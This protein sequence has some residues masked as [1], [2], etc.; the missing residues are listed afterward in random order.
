MI[1]FSATLIEPI[2]PSRCRSSG[3]RPTPFAIICAGSI[4]ETSSLFKIILPASG[5]I[6]P[7]RTPARA[8][9]PF[10]DTPAIP[11]ISPPK[12]VK[13][14]DFKLSRRPR[15][16][17]DKASSC[18]TG[19]PAVAAC[20]MGRDVSLPT[21]MRAI[22]CSSASDVAISPTFLPSLR[23]AILWEN[24]S[25]SRSL[26]EI[27]ITASPSAAIAAIFSN[28][29]SASCGVSTAVGSSSTR[30]RTFR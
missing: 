18:K 1:I 6:I 27:K 28:S 26:C 24:A 19:A 22:F 17:T 15:P 20:L 14:T 7:E 29:V 3:M 23:T 12:T 8:A 9:W 25:T 21:I 2:I 10:P 11:K 13:L 30:I 4:C 16:T 5:I